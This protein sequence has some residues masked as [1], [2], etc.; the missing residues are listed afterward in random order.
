MRGWWEALGL[1]SQEEL[2]KL[3]ML[4]SKSLLNNVWRMM[5]KS[6]LIIDD[7]PT[8]NLEVVGEYVQQFMLTGKLYR[9]V[10]TEEEIRYFKVG[11]LKF[12]DGKPVKDEDKYN[13]A[14]AVL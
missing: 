6:E 9:G 1:V 12:I 8:T 4:N 5:D 10:L 3:N 14:M 11:A 7:I 2:N 13:Q